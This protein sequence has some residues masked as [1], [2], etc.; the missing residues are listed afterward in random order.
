MVAHYYDNACYEYDISLLSI[1]P[2]FFLPLVNFCIFSRNHGNL[3]QCSFLHNKITEQLISIQCGS[4]TE[5]QKCSD[6]LGEL[7]V[8]ELENK[9]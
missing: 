1:L 8:I 3:T 2:F 4:F 7:Q 9:T 5:S 6:I